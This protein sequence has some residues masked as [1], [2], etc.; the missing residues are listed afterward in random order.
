MK[1]LLKSQ[2]AH[3]V[4]FFV[5]AMSIGILLATA[6]AGYE[7]WLSKYP[8]GTMTVSIAM[9]LVVTV[10]LFIHDDAKEDR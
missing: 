7:L 10:N 9:F 5:N 6:W 1:R 2:F 3:D 4:K 8:L